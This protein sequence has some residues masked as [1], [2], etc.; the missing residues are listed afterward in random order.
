MQKANTQSSVP[1]VHYPEECSKAKVVEN[2]QYT[3]ALTRERLKLCVGLCV[4]GV[5]WVCV[6]WLLIVCW[7]VCWV[8]CC[9]VCCVCWVV[10]W[11]VCWGC[12]LGLC[13]GVVCW[14]CVGLC[15][16]LCVGVRV[17]VC[18]GLCVGV[19]VGVLLG[20]LLC[21]LL[22]FTKFYQ[23][24]LCF[25]EFC[26]GVQCFLFALVDVPFS[27]Q[28]VWPLSG[29]PHQKLIFHCKKRPKMKQSWGPFFFRFWS[30]PAPP[31]D[32]PSP[33]RPSSRPLLRR[34]AQNFAFFSF[35][36]RNFTLSSLSLGVFSWNFGGVIEA[37]GHLNVH[38]PRRLRGRQ[39][40]TRQPENSKRAH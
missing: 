30:L 25:P 8:V 14:V 28:R 33:D 34:T 3:I 15:V 10:C 6:A 18:V 38:E 36:R 13:V 9:V 7:V 32:R 16:G 12:V 4:L 24:L 23:V 21:V 27:C 1:R 5:C 20:V 26:C 19:C 22:S 11:V 2:C 31:P 40:F 35:S 17:G 39:G 29:Y 37:P